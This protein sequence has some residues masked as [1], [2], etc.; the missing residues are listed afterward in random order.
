MF[1]LGGL[2]IMHLALFLLI[3]SALK[4]MTYTANSKHLKD[5]KVRK[6]KGDTK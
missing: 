4:D 6:C 5:N 1:E 3:R 2:S